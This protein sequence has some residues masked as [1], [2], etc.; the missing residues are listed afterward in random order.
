MVIA[1]WVAR[2]RWEALSAAERQGFAPLRPDFVIELR[3]PGNRLG[4]VQEKIRGVPR[5]AKL[6]G[7]S[8]ELVG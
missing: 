8:P 6:P 1:S 7:Q 3:W 4:D 5:A 2:E